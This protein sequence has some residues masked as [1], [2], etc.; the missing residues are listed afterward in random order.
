ML[1][2]SHGSQGLPIFATLANRIH[3]VIVKGAWTWSQSNEA[4]WYRSVLFSC[5]WS[6]ELSSLYVAGTFAEAQ[7]D[8]TI[9]CSKINKKMSSRNGNKEFDIVMV[10]CF[11]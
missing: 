9:N 8:G 3:K 10:A 6:V 5:G 11:T 4:T 2:D 7:S 1:N